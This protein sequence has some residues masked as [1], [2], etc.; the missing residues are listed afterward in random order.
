MLISGSVCIHIFFLHNYVTRWWFQIC[1]H[2]HPYLGKIPML[3]SIFFRWV[4]STTNQKIQSLSLY[5]FKTRNFNLQVKKSE[6]INHRSQDPRSDLAV[7]LRLTVCA[8]RRTKEGRHSWYN[9][10]VQDHRSGKRRDLRWFDPRMI[11]L[12]K[13]ISRKNTCLQVL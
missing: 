7:K 12:P 4:G 6:P 3:T 13:E 10:V 2:F 9:G 1:F 11:R 5:N 8:F